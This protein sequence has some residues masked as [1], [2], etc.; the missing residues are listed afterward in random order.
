MKNSLKM[1][2]IFILA[3]LLSLPIAAQVDN[4][5]QIHGFGGWAGGYTDNDNG[6]ALIANHET[7]LANYY[8]GVNFSAQPYKNVMIVAQPCWQSNLAGSDMALDYIFGQWM[9]SPKFGVKMGKIKNPVG[10]YSEILNVGTL[11]PFYLAPQGRYLGAI[12]AYSGVGFIGTFNLDPL[13]ISYHLFGGSQ[14]FETM[15][16]EQPIGFDPI[17]MAPKFISV[18]LDPE[19]RNLVGGRLMFGNPAS[20][21]N[22]GASATSSTLYYSIG[23]GSYLK[24]S[25]K[26]TKTYAGQA[27]Y[28]DERLLLRGEYWYM[29]NPMG[30]INNGFAEAAY[31]FTSHW[32]AAVDYDWVHFAFYSVDEALNRHKAFGAGLA[33]WV[34]QGLVFKINHYW[35]KGNNLA[36]PPSSSESR[37]LGTLKEKTNVLVFGMQC[38]F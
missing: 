35:V 10:I 7:P 29:D 9:L 22:F 27:E 20:G 4:S 13:D 2:T 8:F 38:S 25:D 32:Q 31:K 33:Y 30:E 18:R 36:K 23:G 28:T 14:K 11:R 12:Q 1:V 21:L 19:G 34:Y 24:V 17:T 26:R 16:I 15:V 6:F 37:V 3:P 5:V